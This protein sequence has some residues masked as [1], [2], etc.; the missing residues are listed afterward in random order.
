MFDIWHEEIINSLNSSKSI[1]I[2]TFNSNGKLIDANAA[3]LHTKTS[4][5]ISIVNPS[6]D[7]LLSQTKDNHFEGIVTIGSIESLNTSFKAKVFRKSEEFLLIG[8]IDHREISKQNITLAE[9]NRTNSNLRRD[10]IKEKKLLQITHKK[11]EQLNNDQNILLGTAA[12]DLRN[13]LGSA[14]ALSEFL[15]ND[16]NSFSKEELLTN[17]EIIKSSVSYSLNLLDSLLDLSSIKSGLIVLNKNRVDYIKVL[18]QKISNNTFVANKKNINIKLATNIKEQYIDI[19][20]IRIGQVLNNLISN[21]IKYSNKES[22]ITINF[23]KNNNAYITSVSD[24][25]QGIDSKEID[26]MFDPY[27]ITSTKSTAN[28]KSTG[29]GLSIVKKVIDLHDGKLMVQSSLGIGTTISFTL[30]M[31]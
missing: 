16:F 23:T 5:Q 30:P 8:E 27:Q 26:K 28:E 31:V 2:G 3:M 9:L 10:L 19:D 15:V 22:T 29:L 20:E 12:H 13:P 4:N 21:A 7:H 14:F 1:Y 11:L 17:L 18:Q 25:G 24:E 6:I